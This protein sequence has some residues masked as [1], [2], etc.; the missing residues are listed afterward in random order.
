MKVLL[1]VLTFLAGSMAY[2]EETL[3]YEGYGEFHR[4]YS[5]QYGYFTFKKKKGVASLSIVA[6]GPR[7]CYR[8]GFDVD[9][10]EMR[11]IQIQKVP[12]LYFDRSVSKRG[13]VM[14]DA[15]DEQIVCA[16]RRRFFSPKQTGL[17]RIEVQGARD[18]TYTVKL[19]VDL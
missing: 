18:S 3:V 17:C 5:A 12:G 2:A 4:A 9:C 7:R 8:S 15:G 6:E 16:T 10:H 19:Y 1:L 14:Y 13:A 11:L